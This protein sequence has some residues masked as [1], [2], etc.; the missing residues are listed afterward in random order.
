M[1]K[2]TALFLALALC[3]SLCTV[4]AFA[5]PTTV[6]DVLNKAAGGFP[7]RHEGDAGIPENAWT[8]DNGN[9]AY[10]NQKNSTLGFYCPNPESINTWPELTQELEEQPN[11][12]YVY[13]WVGFGTFTFKMK[14]DALV[15]IEVNATDELLMPFSGTYTKPV[16]IADV[17]ATVDG[18]FPAYDEFGKEWTNDNEFMAYISSTGKLGFL[19]PGSG[20][21]F[22]ELSESVT[23]NNGNYIY[24]HDYSASGTVTIT[25]NMQGGVLTSV[26]FVG[27]TG[28]KNYDKFNGTYTA[29]TPTYTATFTK[30]EHVTSIQYKVND[31]TFADYTASVTD[32][33][34]GDKVTIKVTCDEGYTY[35][36]TTEFTVSTADI[37]E[38]INATLKPT[39]HHHG[40]GST[41]PT[42][43]SA[44]TADMG[45]AI[46]GVLSVSSLLGMGWV[47][48]KK[49]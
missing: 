10:I 33:A 31:G 36:G 17:L 24:T 3:L 13:S 11:G 40:G 27:T 16:T 7:T 25:F 35:N 8:A 4:T 43:T 46:Y 28:T 6:G 1:K 41:T 20:S 22:I 45:V 2:I 14:G 5:E 12:N 29:P 48:K 15:S 26:N 47:S 9:K 42:V 23:E 39:P 18:G 34:E 38:T 49:R 21:H 44:T 30:G 32:L 19:K 37:N